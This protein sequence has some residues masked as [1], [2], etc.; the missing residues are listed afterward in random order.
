MERGRLDEAEAL[1][2]R[3]VDLA[4]PKLAIARATLADIRAKRDSTLPL[5]ATIRTI[6]VRRDTIR[7]HARTAP[8]IRRLT[9]RRAARGRSATNTAILRSAAA[10]DRHR[11]REGLRCLHDFHRMPSHGVL[12]SIAALAGTLALAGCG[13]DAAFWMTPEEKATRA[14]PPS[15]AF[16]RAQAALTGAQAPRRHSAPRSTNAC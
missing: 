12:Q 8:R 14:F 9:D 10:A 6:A 13:Q 7:P 5:T 15:E 16:K 1:A 4:G 11:P 3:A 2:Q